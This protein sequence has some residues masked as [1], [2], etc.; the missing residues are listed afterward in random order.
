MKKTIVTTLLVLGMGAQAM[1]A[2]SPARQRLDAFFTKVNSL[3]GSFTQRVYDKR[4]AVIQNSSG[5]LYLSRPGRFRWVYMRPEPQEIVSDG[6]NVWVYDEELEQVT[7]KPVSAAVTATP[8]AV[9]TR[10]D[11]PGFRFHIKQLPSKGGQDWFK[12]VPKAANR[13]FKF[14]EMGLD[15]RGQ[16]KRMV[17]HDQLGQRTELN[18]NMQHNVP[19]SGGTFYFQIPKGTDVIGR[20]R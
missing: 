5:L 4:G 18:L 19:I 9:L 7:I 2:D 14:I 12:L 20:A 15:A 8:A 16:L 3:K 13:D 1:A 6:R 10:R 11:P 17:M